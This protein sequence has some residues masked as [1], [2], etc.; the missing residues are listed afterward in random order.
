MTTSSAC[1]LDH[2]DMAASEVED[3]RT[4]VE[5]RAHRSPEPNHIGGCECCSGIDGMTGE[6][7]HGIVDGAVTGIESGPKVAVH[8]LAWFRGCGSRR[9]EQAHVVSSAHRRE[10]A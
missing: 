9:N 3:R 7:R 2:L 5:R 10:D 6:D 1:G 4:L 8:N